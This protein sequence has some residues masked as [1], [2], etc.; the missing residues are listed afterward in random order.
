M[1]VITPSLVKSYGR[2]KWLWVPGANGIADTDA[3]TIGELS[4]VGVLDLTGYLFA[5]QFGGPTTT[6]NKGTLPRRFSETVQYQASGTRTWDM[7]DLVLAVDPQAAPGSDG[8]KALE[9]LTEGASGFLVQ[10]QGDLASVD[11]A[12]GDYVNVYPVSVDKPLASKT[13][14]D[15]FAV[16]ALSQSVSITAEPTTLVAVT[17]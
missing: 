16:F 9:A 7:P 5:D 13:G 3:P 17:A 6:T 11:I 4:A 14:N 2:E 12:T 8:K 15:E 10:R 1:A